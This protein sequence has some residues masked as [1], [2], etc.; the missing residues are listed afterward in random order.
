MM[1]QDKLLSFGNAVSDI[2]GAVFHYRRS[3]LSPPYTVWQEEDADFLPAD[4]SVAEQS[5]RGTL[6]Y[7]TKQEYDP[8]VDEIQ[9]V[10]AGIP[11]SW[12]LNSVQFEEDT[13]II[14]Y[15]WVWFWS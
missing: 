14:H 10:L 8:R 13:G 12:Y 11:V 15:E 4:N 6:D 2:S 1:F 9:T 7:Y 5:P 3:K